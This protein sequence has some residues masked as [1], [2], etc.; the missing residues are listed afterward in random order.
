MAVGVVAVVGRGSLALKLL[1]RV[2]SSDYPVLV[3]DP[4]EPDPE[5][6]WAWLEGDLDRAV[7]SGLLTDDQRQRMRREVVVDPRE[8]CLGECDLVLEAEA[9]ILHDKH[10]LLSGLQGGMSPGAT[11]V[12]C[13]STL[14]VDRFA[15]R[16]PFPEQ[17]L[18]AAIPLPIT[19]PW[20][21]TLR[22]TER[23]APGVVAAAGYF[24]QAL[25]AQADEVQVAEPAGTL[26][27]PTGWEGATS[28]LPSWGTSAVVVGLGTVGGFDGE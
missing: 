24:F 21:V 28:G 8:L 5:A 26:A 23:T 4:A 2:V 6:R 3:H 15:P 27:A 18:A 19:D 10:R 1:E 14:P 20:R 12:A 7:A 11:L 9:A 13:S 17:F 16:L 22:T 25:G